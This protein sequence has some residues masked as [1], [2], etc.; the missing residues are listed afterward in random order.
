[1]DT[2]LHDLGHKIYGAFVMPGDVVLSTI[3]IIGDDRSV[4]MLVVLSLA[5]WFLV[6][7]AASIIIK[8]IRNAARIVGA[9][10]RTVMFR[11]SLAVGN[12]KTKMILKLRGFLPRRATRRADA[13][14]TVEFD[15]LDFAVLRSAAARGPGF[16]TSAPELAEQLTL[17]PAQIQRSLDKLSQNRML[18]YVIGSTD[19]FDNYRLSQLGTAFVMSWERQGA[20]Q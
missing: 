7:V 20:R 13:I 16:T 3:G 10:I 19:G 5:V 15:D 11:M 1:M 4:V 12:F 9:L 2:V 6:V 14:P 8:L 18:E 17:R